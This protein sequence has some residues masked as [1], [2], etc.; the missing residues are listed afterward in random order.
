MLKSNCTL[1]DHNM[2]VKINNPR[3][4]LIPFSFSSLKNSINIG[5]TSTH[6]RTI[7]MNQFDAVILV[8]KEW[9]PSKYRISNPNTIFKSTKD[10][11]R[12]L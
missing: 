3:I 5:M 2:L 9:V 7:H 8:A 11:M 4:Y 10:G 1:N 12:Y 6:E